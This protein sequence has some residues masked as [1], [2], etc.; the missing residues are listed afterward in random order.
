ME[1]GGG[2]P[3]SSAVFVDAI[4]NTHSILYGS[5]TMRTFCFQ[6]VAPTCVKN[7]Q[8]MC[9]QPMY[10]CK[11]TGHSGRSVCST[12]PPCNDTS[13]AA[14]GWVWHA[15]HPV[16]ADLAH[17]SPDQSRQISLLPGPAR[18]GPGAPPHANGGPPSAARRPLPAARRPPS[19]VRC[20]PSAARRPP[21]TAHRHRSSPSHHLLPTDLL[22]KSPTASGNPCRKRTSAC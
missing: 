18:S 19:A 14:R 6:A 3:F 13:L 1:G 17:F 10:C 12:V 22:N 7:L 21:P 20:P 9:R 8:F 15:S 16:P 2:T 4:R 11:I 5:H